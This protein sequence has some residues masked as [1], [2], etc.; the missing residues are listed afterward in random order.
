MPDLTS[1]YSTYAQNTA[2]FPALYTELASQLGVTVESVIKAEVGFIP[3]DE[4]GNQAWAF[5]E[6]NAK[7]GVTCIQER[8]NNGKKYTVKGS[9]RGLA[10]MVSHDTTQYEKNGRWERVSADRPCPLCG[11][12]DGC[13]YPKE[14]YNN[15]NAVI[16][17]TTK[18]G[19]VKSMELGYL[20]IL[21]PARQKLQ[22][23]NY[24]ILLP[25]EHP[26]LVVEGWT[27]VLAAYD[28]GFT[29]VGKPSA[30]SKSKDLIEL[31]SGH[32]VVILGEN[33]AGA[34]KAGMESTFV[35]LQKA[36]PDCTKIMPPEGVKDLRQWV[37]K[38]L[39][40]EELLDY[41]EKVGSKVLDSEIFADDRSLTVASTW[42]KDYKTTNNETSLGIYR[43]GYV[44][45]DGHCYE[46]LADDQVHGQLY[47][48]I[49]S[50]SYVDAT[51][52]IKP[53]KLTCAKVRDILQACSSKCL[54]ESDPPCWL[55]PG[56]HPDPTKLIVFQNGIL[57]IDRYLVDDTA[58]MMVNPDPKLF[59]FNALPY[60][61]DETLESDL[62]NDTKA[63]I[64][65]EHPDKLRLL[66]QW[67]GYNLV[68]DM[69][70][71]KFML[72]KGRIRSGKG[73]LAHAL[74]AMLG[75]RNWCATDFGD[76]GLAGPF[77]YHPLVGKLCAVVGDTT[78]SRS[79]RENTVL[80][81][82]LNIV[83]RDSVSI[84]VKGKPHLPDIALCCRFTFAMN[85]FPAFRDDSG[86]LEARTNILTFDNSYLGRED[87]TL[88]DRLA[89]EATSGKLINFALR[90]LKDLYANGE[91]TVPAESVLALRTFRELVSPIPQF[92][93][94]C[95]E[96]DKEGP[97]VSTDYLYDLWK[98]WC[99]REGLKH[100]YKSTLIRNLLSTVPDAMQIMDGEVGNPDRMIMGIKVTGWAEKALEQ[101]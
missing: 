90:G 83:G 7:G 66:A 79:G 16:C 28:L 63:D 64:F 67:F 81:K 8:L 48:D 93:Q 17:V 13:M 97:G 51:G 35:R 46:Q 76:G 98:W 23:Q 15:P 84:N 86:A 59:T 42:I 82:I 14:E 43:K 34:G 88:K 38:G 65:N 41:I 54:I 29:A 25:S 57:D 11:H 99:S 61:F 96:L 24:S 62:W 1:L 58:H 73:T 100:G 22:M 3:V 32:K 26:N 78:A 36:C 5:P 44:D 53:Y 39:T 91:F 70:Q 21:D 74:K 30:A 2:R 33:D 19:S 20:H 68:P 47:R 50:R 69:S 45:F 72:F 6:R 52:A 95:T 87:K 10:Y 80:L 85:D 18:V 12:P 75:K 9:R 94:Y 71:E 55:T 101:G 27:D 40:R 56:E 89:K 60:D 4:H 49:G 77:G 37:L 31:L 92:T